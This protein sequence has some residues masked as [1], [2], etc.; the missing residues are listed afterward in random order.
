[1]AKFIGNRKIHI[2]GP[3]LRRQKIASLIS[4]FLTFTMI[5]KPVFEGTSGWETSLSGSLWNT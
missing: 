4:P 1:M 5:I 3:P 2:F